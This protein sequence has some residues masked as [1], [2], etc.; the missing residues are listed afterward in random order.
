MAEYGERYRKNVKTCKAC[1]VA[2]KAPTEKFN[3][4]P[5]TDKPWERL[6]IGFAGPIKGQYYL[7]V[8]GFQ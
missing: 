7:N 3:L 4:W 1:A 8:V 6:H 2:T 5:K